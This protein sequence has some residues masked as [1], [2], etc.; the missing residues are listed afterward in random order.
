MSSSVGLDNM[1]RKL[2]VHAVKLVSLMLESGKGTGEAKDTKDTHK[3]VI[4]LMRPQK[5]PATEY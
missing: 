4:M 2:F 5:N 1:V 3:T